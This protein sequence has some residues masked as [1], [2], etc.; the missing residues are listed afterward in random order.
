MSL[1]TLF[2]LAT[3]AVSALAGTTTLAS[4]EAGPSPSGE[5]RIGSPALR[6]EGAVRSREAAIAWLKSHGL[7]DGLRAR[8]EGERYAVRPQNAM[9]LPRSTD[10]VEAANPAQGLEA[11]FTRGGVELVPDATATGQWRWGMRLAAYGYSGGA[12]PLRGAELSGSGNR[13]EYHHGSGLSEWY[14]NT[15]RGIEQGFTLN[16]VPRAGAPGP[17]ELVLAVSGDLSPRLAPGGGVIHFVSADGRAVLGYRELRAWDARGRALPSRMAVGGGQVRLIIDDLSPM[18]G[19]A[20]FV[21]DLPLTDAISCQAPSV[22]PF[23]PF[24]TWSVP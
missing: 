18:F 6:A 11:R 9:A 4:A 5:A 8:V 22:R 10:R 15:S 13:V 14:V 1:S 16:E 21:V 23:T 19:T 3:L 17:L 2:A 12:E 7:Y 20:V 24:A